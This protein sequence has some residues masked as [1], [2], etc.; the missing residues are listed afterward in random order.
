M[1][2]SKW[3]RI[4]LLSTTV[5][6]AGSANAQ[7]TTAAPPAAN[8]QVPPD[9]NSNQL[10]EVVV[11]AQKRSEKLSDVP[12]SVSA[13]SGEQLEARGVTQAADLDKVVPGFNFRPSNYGTPVYTIRGVGFFENSVAVAPTVSVYVDQV[14]M[15]YSAMTSGAAIDLERVEVLKGPQGTL[16]GQNSTG[17]AINYIANKPTPQFDTG[18]N[19][20]YGNFKAFH[21]DGFVSGP[22]TDTLSARL[23]LSTDQRG[24]WQKSQTRDDTLGHRNFTTGRL[25]VDWKPTDDL[26]FEVN[27]NGWRDRSDSQAAQFVSFSPTRPTGYQDVAP[28]LRAYKPAPNDARIAD[29]DPNTSLRRSDSFYQASL[30]GDWDLSDNVTLSSI[31]SYAGLHQNAPTDADGT[32]V[33]NFH[34]VLHTNIHSFS[35]EVRLSGRAIDE[36]LKW[37]A[38]VNYDKSLARDRPLTDTIASNNGLGPRRWPNYLLH[39]DQDVETKAAFGSL[40]YN[41]TQTVTV[42]GSIRYTKSQNDFEGCL[43]DPGNGGIAFVF[44]QLS[45]RPIKPGECVTLAPPNNTPAGV[46]RKSLDEDNL[47]W[48]LGLSWKPTTETLL[49]ASLTKGYKAGSFPTLAALSPDQFDPITQESLLAYETGFKTTLLDR[50]LQLTGALFYYDYQDKQLIGYKTTPFGNLPGF[51]SIPK[52]RVSGGELNATWRPISPLTISAGASYVDSKVT[53]HRITNDPYGVAVDIKDEAFPN[54][55]KWHLTGDIQY[56]F[57]LN[58]SLEGFVGANGQYKTK[59]SAAFGGGA[60]FEMP[61]Y[62]L[63][64]LRAGVE[65]KDS[66]WKV[67]VW[68]R[69]VTDKF[70]INN[71]SHIVDTVARNTGMP[72]TYGVTLG[73][74]Y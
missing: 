41:L 57:D 59:T 63:L 67:T 74:R 39:N 72:A 50:T 54:T 15:A 66:H 2:N 4:A 35:Q 44:S 70:Y 48:R 69:N 68:G 19:V 3:L 31:T 9:N 52:S 33:G 64:D 8:S 45:S 29:W 34:R 21:G 17:G 36:R 26:A 51:I 62:G 28:I 6:W 16:F 65:S 25:L 58:D 32:S 11:T 40:D 37:M 61:A 38:G 42:Q 5:I 1:Q 13:S 23:A 7:T 46:V 49:Y 56:T 71:I 30:R 24:D 60:D 20:G 55:P 73:Y 10:E 12:M 22:L 27:L 14:P 43:L 53:S 47:S 18:F